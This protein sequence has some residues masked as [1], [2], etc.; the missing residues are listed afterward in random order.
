MEDDPGQMIGSTEQK[1]DVLEQ[2][3]RVLGVFFRTRAL[4][5]SGRGAESE[6]RVVRNLST[7]S[8]KNDADSRSSW[9]CLVRYVQLGGYRK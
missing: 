9:V 1:E 6:T 7:L 3:S 8:G 2:Q 5:P 4:M